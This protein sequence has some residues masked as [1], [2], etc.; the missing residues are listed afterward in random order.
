M[1]IFKLLCV[2]TVIFQCCLAQKVVR[3]YYETSDVSA[4][5][6]A[7]PAF[8]KLQN[9]STLRTYVN[10]SQFKETRLFTF[11]NNKSIFY[12]IV[13]QKWYY[14]NNK[15]WKLFYDFYGKKGGVVYLRGG[16]YE[17]VF[18]KEITIQGRILHK[19]FF[20]P[21][22]IFQSHKLAYYFDPKFGV[23]IVQNSAG[24]VLL[25]TNSFIKKLNESELDS[26]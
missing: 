9:F 22:K 8:G 20:K 18:D 23:V 7:S 16:A 10:D 11:D 12:R 19:L 13:N 5:K 24:S 26:L 2:F 1:K 14:K 4:K 21:I 3:Y 17:V 25:R 15:K 6:E